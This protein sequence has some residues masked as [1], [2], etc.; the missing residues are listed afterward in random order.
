MDAREV[1]AAAL[2]QAVAWAGHHG[3]DWDDRE[4]VKTAQRFSEFIA[5][6]LE[7]VLR[8]VAA[9]VRVATSRLEEHAS[10]DIWGPLCDGCRH[11][12]GIH[13]VGGCHFV[14]PDHAYCTCAGFTRRLPA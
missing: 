6:D 8:Q 12:E 7:P 11:S 13:K 4:I 2:T 1:R 9:P 5:G 10:A 3:G 14:R